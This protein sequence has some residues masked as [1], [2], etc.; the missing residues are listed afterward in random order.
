MP[1]TGLELN[2]TFKIEVMI[3]CN[4]R[5]VSD[6]TIRAAIAAGACTVD[7]VADA[8]RGA[9]ACCGSCRPAIAE[10]LA[11]P[12]AADALLRRLSRV[13]PAHSDGGSPRPACSRVRVE[14]GSPS[15][16]LVNA[17]AEEAA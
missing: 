10:M 13:P 12:I 8:C 6:Q 16:Y 14:V 2:I 1:L 11:T 4:C 3:V 5:G 7:D 17:L 15:P 9:G